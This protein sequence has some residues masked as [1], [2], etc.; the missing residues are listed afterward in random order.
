MTKLAIADFFKMLFLMALAVGIAFLIFKGFYLYAGLG[1]FFLLILSY[2]M[3][4]KHRFLLKQMVE[5]SEAVKYRDFTRRFVVKREKSVEGQLYTAFNQIN[6][7]YKNI[8]IDQA[9]QHQYLNKVINMLDTA[10]IF[11]HA[12]SGKVIWLN[13]AFK[14]LFQVPHLGNISGMQKRHPELYIKT[15]QL[16]VGKHQMETAHSSKGKIKL[17]MQSSGFETQDGSFRIIVYQ[18]INE[19][20]DETE[21]RAWHKLLRVL[22]HEIMN[23]IGPISSLAET[24]HD[25]LEHWEG[26]QDIED[27]KLGIFTIKRRSEGLLQFAKSYRLINKVDQPQFSEILVV[28]LFEN[29]YQLLEPTLIQKNIDVDII[30]K[31]TRMILRADVNLLEQVIIN[32]LLNAIEAVKEEEEPY[33][34]LSAIET[35]DHIQ[36]KIQ[37]NGAGM[38]PEI[39]EQ[40]FTPFFTTKKTGTGVGLTL[41]KQIMLMHGGNISV[42]SVEGEGSTFTLQF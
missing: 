5:F 17:L 12:E 20:I 34:S 21:T 31:N 33:I 23:S 18:N 4:S 13:E 22:T 7:V 10:I 16:Q 30:I 14:E 36:L 37:D 35:K 2:R 25:R 19:A 32:L 39:Q 11:Y 28:Q 3:F 6:E 24:L 15:M 26:E 38:S 9:L 29:I 41:S 27:L 8:S 40:I 42:D 1:F